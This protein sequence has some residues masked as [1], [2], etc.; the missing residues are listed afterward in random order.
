V[1]ETNYAAHL[2]TAFAGM[3]TATQ[4]A[5][6]AIQTVIEAL[7]NGLQDES[8]GVVWTQVMAAANER[9]V[10]RIDELTRGL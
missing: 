3:A 4:H 7:N 1:S 6:A 10:A 2:S 5:A 8:P 9:L